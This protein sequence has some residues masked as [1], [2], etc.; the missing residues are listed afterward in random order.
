MNGR[1]DNT[2]FIREQI[3]QCNIC[4][5][6]QLHLKYKHTILL[7]ERN[8]YLFVYL[9]VGNVVT[10]SLTLT[11]EKGVVIYSNLYGEKPSLSK[12]TYILKY[13]WKNIKSQNIIHY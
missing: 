9:Y 3:F 5:L 7:N 10:L 6:H 1:A 2:N 4:M 11:I 12:L 8:A 13:S